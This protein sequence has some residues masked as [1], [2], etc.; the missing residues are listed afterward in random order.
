MENDGSVSNGTDGGLQTTTS[1]G[2]KNSDLPGTGS[3]ENGK[4]SEQ[5]ASATDDSKKD[6]NS[7]ESGSD[8]SKDSK[9][10]EKA[11][12]N[13]ISVKADQFCF[14]HWII[15]VIAL[16]GLV[17]TLLA[18]K[19]KYA[20]IIAAIDTV[21]MLI[22]VIL[23]SCRWDLVTML[24]GVVLLVVATMIRIRRTSRTER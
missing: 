11:D 10:V 24:I 19:R 7:N 13:T 2:K 9:D 16:I 14:W 12:G 22:G 15:A 5:T 20:V 8:S 23:G 17:L 1:T 6:N 4:T 21:L 18:R 3:E